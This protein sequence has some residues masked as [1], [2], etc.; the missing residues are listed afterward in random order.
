MALFTNIRLCW[1]GLPGQTLQLIVKGRK[2]SQ[3][4]FHE[5][6]TWGQCYK[7]FY[8]RDLRIFVIS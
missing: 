3:K 8:G 2:L 6:D 4:M 5:I 7:A 1:K